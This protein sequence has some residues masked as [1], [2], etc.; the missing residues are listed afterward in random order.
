MLAIIY[1]GQGSQYLGMCK[2]FYDNFPKVRDIFAEISEV[3]NINI[4]EII[5]E[6]KNSQLNITEYTQICIYT[7]SISIFSVIKDLYSEKIKAKTLYMAGHSLGEYSAISA[8]NSI[9]ISECGK[10]LKLR[11]KY[12]QNSSPEIPSGMLVVIGLDIEI[13]ESILKKEENKN[14]FEIA[15]HNGLN[16]IVISL[17]KNKF[18]S[19]IEILNHHNVKKILPL[20][21]SAGFHSNFMKA[22]SEK[23][24]LEIDK[25][26]F[27]KS[28]FPIVS[29]FNA[30]SSDQPDIISYNLKQQMV[31]KVKWVDII[32]FFEY[33]KVNTIIEIGPNKILNGL[34]K[35][36]SKNFEFI[37]VSSID[38]L[39]NLKNVF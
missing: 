31:N 26:H 15:N 9:S 29:N 5:F 6:D 2:D 30:V 34:N 16:Q 37:N 1:P 22:A 18:D 19:V 11:G 20:N 13:I 36:I 14:L 24:N 4:K 21:V 39:E 3:T 25:L 7:V 35:R 23:M 38:E 28:E 32:K 17:K 8:S 33:K 10:L 12:M 27:K